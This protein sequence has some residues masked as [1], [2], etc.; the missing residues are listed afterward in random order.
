M[1][2]ST[3]T[4]TV[5]GRRYEKLADHQQWS[6]LLALIR[7]KPLHANYGSRYIYNAEYRECLELLDAK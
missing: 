1:G 5:T 4:C 6:I 3:V 2:S 7:I